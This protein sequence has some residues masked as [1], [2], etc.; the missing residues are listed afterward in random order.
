M[1][2]DRVIGIC[3]LYGLN[4]SVRTK[5]G[6]ELLFNLF[7]FFQVDRQH[8]TRVDLNA[9]IHA[10]AVKLGEVSAIFGVVFVLFSCRGRLRFS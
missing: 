7:S 4:F 5:P 8:F 10:M 2:Q 6:S 9:Q 3:I 1:G